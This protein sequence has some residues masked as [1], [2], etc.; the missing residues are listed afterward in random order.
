V[1]TTVA[2]KAKEAILG[3]SAGQVLPEL[4][5]DEA[6]QRPLPF[7]PARQKGLE[8]FGDDLIKDSS[9][10]VP[11]TLKEKADNRP[12]RGENGL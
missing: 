10:R 8:L 2:V 7:L 4:A 9:F 12:R 5:L 3:N 6:G 11:G 1:A